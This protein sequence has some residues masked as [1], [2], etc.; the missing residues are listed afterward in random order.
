LPQVRF[1]GLQI[2]K[3]HWNHKFASAHNF[4][5]FVKVRVVMAHDLR[6][7]ALIRKPRRDNFM[8]S[9]VGNR[10]AVKKSRTSGLFWRPASNNMTPIDFRPDDI[11]YPPVQPV[12]TR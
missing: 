11:S 12:Q 4:L 6:K 5:K 1:Q 7:V 9:R 2:E 10:P 3:R 8:L